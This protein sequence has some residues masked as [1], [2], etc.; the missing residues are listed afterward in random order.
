MVCSSLPSF[1]SSL[2]PRT[3]RSELVTDSAC[4]VAL[5]IVFRSGERSLSAVI[6]TE[7]SK[8]PL[9]RLV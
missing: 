2:L 8:T 1:I 6:A 3:I 4:S 9:N 5:G 7:G